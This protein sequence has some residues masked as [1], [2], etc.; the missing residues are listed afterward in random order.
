[1]L[2]LRCS[3]RITR[4]SNELAPRERRGFFFAQSIDAIDGMLGDM[5]A[6]IAKKD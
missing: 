6:A 4:D 3:H 1:M 2:P 5:L